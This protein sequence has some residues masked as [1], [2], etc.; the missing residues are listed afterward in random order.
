MLVKSI[1]KTLFTLTL[2][3]TIQ[4]QWESDD[5]VIRLKLHLH[6]ENKH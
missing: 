4:N 1:S 2:R 5:E 6:I 3:R